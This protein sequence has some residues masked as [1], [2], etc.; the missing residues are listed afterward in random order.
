MKSA[1]YSEDHEHFRHAIRQFVAEKV[2]PNIGGWEKDEQIPREI[3]GQLAGIDLLGINL[4]KAYGGSEADF[5]FTVV[6]LEELARGASGGFCAAFNVHQFMAMAYISKFGGDSLKQ[7]YLAPGIK[8]ELLGA[9]AVTEP[10]SGSD[11][12]SIRTT[13][14]RDGDFYVVDGCKTFITNGLNAD[15]VVT[16]V[17]TKPEGGPAGISLLIIDR[18][19]IGFSAGRLNKIGW[20]CSDTAELF[21]DNVRVPADRLIGEEN[22][23]FYYI[24]EGFQL[25][26]LVTAVGAVSAAEYAIESTIGYLNGREA[27]NRPLSKYQAIRH[28]LASCTAELEAARHLNYHAC[29]LY[30][31]QLPAIK[32]STMAKL[33]S[34]ELAKKI[35]DICLQFHGGYGYMQDYPISRMYQ[36]ARAGTI[37]GGT[38]EIMREILSKLTFDSALVS[39][40]KTPATNVQ[41]LGQPTPVQA[42]SPAAVSAGAQSKVGVDSSAKAVAP[43]DGKSGRSESALQGDA[44]Q[45]A[46]G[47]DD[48]ETILRDLPKPEKPVADAEISA[49]Q[50]EIERV[51]SPTDN[52]KKSKSEQASSATRPEKKEEVGKSGASG[53]GKAR[54][55]NSEDNDNFS[56]EEI[57]EIQEELE[58]II[59][60][61]DLPAAASGK[62]NTAAEEP[63]SKPGSEDATVLLT[64]PDIESKFPAS[65]DKKIVE[66]QDPTVAEIFQGLTER[67]RADKAE[68][69]HG[70]F[71]FSI[72]GEGGGNYT[73]MINDGEF[74]HN[75]GLIGE[76]D[77]LIHTNAQTFVDVELGRA[78]QQVS[79]MMGKIKVSDVAQMM[80]FSTFF[81]KYGSTPQ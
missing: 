75:D 62:Q 47:K 50:D 78:N 44:S 68:N 45:K 28:R 16:A 43:K 10:H 31:N 22:M 15:F 54:S 20:K 81:H 5:F 23:G 65:G 37:V 46:V 80:Q 17:R 55:G 30:D 60:N 25:E 39:Q 77:C 33:V 79:F 70:I 58:K 41:N 64:R 72:T 13:A 21:F 76:P 40:P 32:E 12:A 24:M 61:A 59:S 56:Q 38:S 18:D 51:I 73:V 66:K 9:F 6:L 67:F 26:R 57:W 42:D 48:D 52:K 11:V 2:T 69:Y 8:G 4:P 3:W 1:F 14:T 71:H 34:T 74:S 49:F 36:D 19:A 29:W 53:N 27:F 35:M 7:Q 63:D